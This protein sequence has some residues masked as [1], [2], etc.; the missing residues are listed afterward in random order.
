M[1][2]EERSRYNKQYRQIGKD[3]Q[4]KKKAI[5]PD[6]LKQCESTIDVLTSLGTRYDMTAGELREEIKLITAHHNKIML[7]IREKVN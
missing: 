7:R 1:T 2:S 5:L 4:E 6:L 3:R